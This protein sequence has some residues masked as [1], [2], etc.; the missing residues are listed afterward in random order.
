MFGPRREFRPYLAKRLLTT[1]LYG[2]WLL[3]LFPFIYDSRRCQLRRSRWLVLY[4]FTANYFLLFCLVYLGLHQDLRKLEA[5]E[6]N[7]VLE[8]INILISLMSIFSAIVI[9]FMNVWGSKKVERIV[10]ELL[11]L[12]NQKFKGA[13]VTNCPKLNCFVIQKFGTMVSQITN[14]LTVNYAMPGNETLVL[15]VLLSCLMQI[16]VS[17]N[18][19]HY[20]VGILLIYRYVWMINGQLKELVKQVRLNSTTDTSKIRELLSLYSRLLELNRKLID[21]YKYHMILIMTSW[22]AGNIVVIYFLIVFGISMR[23]Y[24]IFLMV[25]PQS[26]L[27]NIWDFWLT[28]SVCDLTEKA[29]RKTSTLLKLFIDLQHKNDQ[30]ERSVNEFAWLCSHRKFDFQPCGLFTIWVSK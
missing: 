6:R 3:G 2:S 16:S 21:A 1:V 22:L 5:F 18:I 10:N 8:C 28:I 24:S 14:F 19:M 7:P 11:T 29:A 23:K 27:V 17:F 4:G 13:K 20:Y 15:V 12:E 30:L 26:L 25:F 9:N